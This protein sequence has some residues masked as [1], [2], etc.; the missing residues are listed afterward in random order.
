M[1]RTFLFFLL[2]VGCAITHG[3][4]PIPKPQVPVQ[5]NVPETVEEKP[6]KLEVTKP[7]VLTEEFTPV[8]NVTPRFV[9]SL[10]QHYDK[11]LPRVEKFFEL[12]LKDKTLIDRYKFDF[13]DHTP[14]MIR[15]A[16]R[17]R[18]SVKITTYQPSLR[19]RVLYPNVIGFHKSGVI[20]L[21]RLKLN[22]EDCR[23][24]GTL[25][26]EYM[27]RLGYSH[28]NDSPDGKENTIPYWFGDKAY[29]LCHEGKI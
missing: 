14:D 15:E 17:K 16:L 19:E 9:L 3:P 10:P 26:H 5:V 11:Y 12:A 27:H 13:S 20:Y 8:T 24:L 2:L 18:L 22:R 23:V 7:V 28:G 21:N 4:K 1:K 25:A 29:Q 6:V